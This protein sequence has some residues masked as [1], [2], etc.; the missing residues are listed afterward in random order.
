MWVMEP[1]LVILLRYLL[2]KYCFIQ[3][4]LPSN[5]W[6]NFWKGRGPADQRT[7]HG[8]WFDAAN[9]PS[10][11]LPLLPATCLGCLVLSV[12]SYLLIPKCADFSLS[13]PPLLAWKCLPNNSLNRLY[14]DIKT[15]KELAVPVRGMQ[16]CCLRPDSKCC[17]CGAMG[18]CYSFLAL[19]PVKH[20]WL[21]LCPSKAWSSL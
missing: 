4:V 3:G 9:K 20:G 11:P 7:K 2:S 14:K 12:A 8:L 10:A 13:H 1:V 18:C 15:K 5:S 19:S 17:R 6:S 21:H 16:V